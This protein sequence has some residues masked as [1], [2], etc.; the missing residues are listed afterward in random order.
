MRAALA[1]ARKGLG[2]T[3]PNP[4]VG[5]VIVVENRIIAKGWHHGAGLPHAEIEA[6]RSLKQ[7]ARNA[8]IYVTLE[9][10]STHGRTPPCCAA[11]VQAGLRRVVYGATD[12][13]PKHAGRADKLLQSQGIQVTSGILSEECIDL[14]RYWNKWIATGLPTS[15]SK[16]P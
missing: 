5:A 16:L 9:P 4:A 11:I 7:P 2:R 13:N 14:N 3:H 1:E 10:C 6:L 8:T 12:P 15:W